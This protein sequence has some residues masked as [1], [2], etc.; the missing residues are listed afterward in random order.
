M[1]E[2]GRPDSDKGVWRKT[3]RS[4]IRNGDWIIVKFPQSGRYILW[5]KEKVIGRFNSADEA[6]EKA[7]AVS[8]NV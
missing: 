3:S 2:S 4:T 1:R 6:K 7:D 8:K 5:Y